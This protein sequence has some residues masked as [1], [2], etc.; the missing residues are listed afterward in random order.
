ML[1]ASS[2]PAALAFRWKDSSA[3]A[4]LQRFEMKFR[5]S[6]ST[7][8]AMRQFVRCYLKPDE[9]AARATDFS[10]AVH[11]LYLDSPTLALYEATNGGDNNRFK[12][13]IRYYDADPDSPVFFEI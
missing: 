2:T 12:L 4:Q 6:E 7:A 1:T 3:Q 13:R 5:V 11:T 10:Y 8:R 9:F